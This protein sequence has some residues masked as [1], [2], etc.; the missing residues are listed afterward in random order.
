MPTRRRASW[1]YGTDAGR[2]AARRHIQEAREFSREIGG[3]DR[4][5][6]QYFFSLDRSALDEFFSAYGKA[7]GEKAET[8]ARK[9]FQNWK[10]GSTKM[11]GDV[12]KRLFSLLPPRMPLSAKFKLAE[13]IWRH[14]G[15][16]S[17]S[18]FTVGPMADAKALLNT[19][20]AQLNAN[21]QKF[22]IPEQIKGRFE[23]LS[24][25]EVR[26]KELLLHH[27][28]NEELQLALTKLQH[29]LPLLQEQLNEYGNQTVSVRTNITIQRNSIDIWIDHR[30]KDTFRQGIPERKPFE[31]TIGLG[32][33]YVVA[34]AAFLIL[35]VV[36]EHH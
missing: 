11:S 4:D 25:G 23:W 19:V 15:P 24:A 21:V 28:L 12:A 26:I 36:L 6:K 34:I 9:T 35:L 10:S 20:Y 3:T 5:V 1:D 33:I 30:L 18:A 7:N 13:N 14:F 22:Q 8:Y 27:F 29:E 17:A 2:E 32:A 31:T 16:R